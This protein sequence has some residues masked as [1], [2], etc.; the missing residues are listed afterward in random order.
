MTVDV[1]RFLGKLRSGGAVKGRELLE[2]LDRV[3]LDAV[4]AWTRHAS[5]SRFGKILKT[6]IPGKKFPAISV[7]GTSC[8]LHCKHCNEHYLHGMIP[9]ETP[10]R[11]E[12]VLTSIYERGGTGA[13]IS[14]GSTRDGVVEMRRFHGVLGR[15]ARS[16]SLQLNLHTGL[17]DEATARAL[18]ETGITAISLDLVGDD[19]TIRDIYGLDKTV[20][21][22]KLVLHGLLRAGFTN[23]HIIPHVCIGLDKGKVVGEYAVLDYIRELNPALVVFIIIIPPKQQGNGGFS[24]VPPDDVSRLVAMTRVL[25]PG[26]EISLGCMRPG[27]KIRDEYDIAAFKAAITR[28]AIPTRAVLT[29]AERGGYSIERIENCCAISSPGP[30]SSR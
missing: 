30:P 6:Y 17:I 7:T 9:A 22:Y 25:F 21:D 15:I 26:A 8:E 20:E 4:L 29:M 18:R 1:E 11:L 19:A 28:I 2:S 27:G 10:E 16:T 23:Q 14:G 13:L 24:N 3:S 12:Q 5:D